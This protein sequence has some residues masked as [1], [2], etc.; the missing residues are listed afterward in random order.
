MLENKAI[1]QNNNFK[2]FYKKSS[3]RSLDSIIFE[4]FY[5]S[6]LSKHI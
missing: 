1:N 5:V 6:V 4:V 3:L 2:L